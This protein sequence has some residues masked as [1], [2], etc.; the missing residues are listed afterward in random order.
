MMRHIVSHKSLV[1]DAATTPS[2]VHHV[3][4]ANWAYTSTTHTALAWGGVSLMGVSFTLT[5]VALL[6]SLKK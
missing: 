6:L 5:V 3:L 2:V 4:R 1:C